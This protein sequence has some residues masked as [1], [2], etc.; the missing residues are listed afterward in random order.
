MWFNQRNDAGN[1]LLPLWSIFNTNWMGFG[2]F[3]GQ[4]C[5]QPVQCPEWVELKPNKGTQVA[6]YQG[7]ELG[8]WIISTWSDI[9]DYWHIPEPRSEWDQM[10]REEKKMFSFWRN[11]LNHFVVKKFQYV[12]VCLRSQDSVASFL[13]H[14]MVRTSIWGGLLRIQIFNRFFYFIRCIA[15]LNSR[16]FFGFLKMINFCT[17]RLDK[18][19]II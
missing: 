17:L 9:L 13:S 18:A 11:I 7:L 15:N 3:L 8:A 5:P 1:A 2:V 6:T 19:Q 4:P 12:E 14:I 10:K 16:I